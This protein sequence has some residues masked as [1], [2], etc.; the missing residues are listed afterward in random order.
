MEAQEVSILLLGDAEVGKTTFLSRTRPIRLEFSDTSS[1][2][3]YTLLR[4]SLIL[5]CFS[6]PSRESLTSLSTKWKHI[7]ETHFNYDESIPVVVLGL[8]R[9]LRN[10]DGE[11]GMVFPQEGVRVWEDIV[12]TAVATTTEQGGR[13]EPPP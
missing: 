4:P 3:T 5:L 7:V 13:S 8:K 11:E 9:D 10:D 6:I 1:P 2:T 12:K